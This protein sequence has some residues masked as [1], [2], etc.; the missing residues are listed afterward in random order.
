M[1]G[2]FK[3]LVLRSMAEDPGFRD[4]LLRDVVDLWRAGE[5]DLAE[6]MRRD[7]FPGTD[8]SV[9]TAADVG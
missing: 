8:L 4:V 9:L 3:D 6:A 7:Y 2:S 5:T 1:T